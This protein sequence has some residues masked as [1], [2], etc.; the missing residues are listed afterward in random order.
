MNDMTK[1]VQTSSETENTSAPLTIH[2]PF[3]PS[4]AKVQMPKHFI[5]LLNSHIDAEE[6][7]ARNTLNFGSYLAA[8]V[9]Q[10]L[11]LKDEFVRDIGFLEF[12]AKSAQVWI[13][14]ESGRQITKFDLM[15][16]W[17]VRQFKNEFNPIHHHGG[18]ICGVGYLKLPEEFGDYVQDDKHHNL[19]GHIQFIHGSHQ[20]LSS[21]ILS[22]R[23]EVG[24]FYLFPNYLFH[25]VYPFKGNEERRSVSFN[26]I[27]DENIYNS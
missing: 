10:E 26:A 27:I 24:N 13:N 17:V 9:S 8:N 23:P 21:A 7:G 4:I 1:K 11:R 22:A 25:T 6:Q 20:F 15:S 14:K 3:G 5:D 16:C 12:L 19:N 2:R 18:H